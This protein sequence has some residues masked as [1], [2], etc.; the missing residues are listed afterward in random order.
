MFVPLP[1][2]YYVYYFLYR[3]FPRYF[4]FLAWQFLA[5]WI[6]NAILFTIRTSRFVRLLMATFF[7]SL[8]A[9]LFVA[10]I[11]VSII[12]AVSILFSNVSFA[13]SGS[14]PY[15]PFSAFHFL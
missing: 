12:C 3:Q 8:F 13:S 1:L 11:V 9:A 5:W 10:S 15:L 4:L 7:L 2:N 14:S 6:S